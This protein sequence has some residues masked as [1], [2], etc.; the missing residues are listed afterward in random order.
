[1]T[2]LTANLRVRD[3]ETHTRDAECPFCMCGRVIVYC[4]DETA[5]CRTCG[6]EYDVLGELI[7]I[8]A[9]NVQGKGRE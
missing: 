2:E 3:T 5:T 7:T 4:E 6:T 9:P 8:D 1:M